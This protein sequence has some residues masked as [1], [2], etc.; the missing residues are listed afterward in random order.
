MGWDYVE[1]KIVEAMQLAE[2]DQAVARKHII[3]WTFEDTKLLHE[4]TK[5]HMVGIVGHA[6]GHVVNKKH[7]EEMQKKASAKINLEDELA[8]DVGLEILKAIA[9]GSS[10]R[11]G[12][13]NNSARLG[14]KQASNKHIDAIKKLAVKN[15]EEQG[16]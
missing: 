1:R 13:E 12:L 2:G 10:P 15:P 16:E 7:K 8:G 14:K 5:P 4:L 9:G 3:A 11:F 6:V